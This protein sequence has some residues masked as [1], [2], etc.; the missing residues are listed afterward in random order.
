[1]MISVQ[2]VNKTMGTCDKNKSII[3]LK[4]R[5]NKQFAIKNN[6]TYC[7]NTI[8]NTSPL[9]IIDKTKEVLS[10][11]PQKVRIIL[12]YEDKNT[13]RCVI[14]DAIKAYVT[15]D[16]VENSLKDFT[17]GHFLRGVD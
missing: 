15:K 14:E 10:L 4:D 1:M 9:Y 5:K 3:Y 7:Y 6:C 12:T 17:R 13:A 2:C 11:A 16:N 8:Y